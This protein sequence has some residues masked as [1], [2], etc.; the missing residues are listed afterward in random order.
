MIDK[1]YKGTNNNAL[2]V[3]SFCSNRCVMCCQPPLTEENQAELYD[4]NIKLIASAD[5][6]TDYVCITGGEPTLI[7]ERLFEYMNKIWKQMPHCCIHLLSNGR[8]FSKPKYIER[9]YEETKSHLVIGIPLHS[10]NYLDHD[11]IAGSKGA[12]YETIKG[13]HNLGVLGYEIE[14]RVVILKQNYKRL[15]K[16]AEFIIHN[17]PFVSQVSFMGLEVVGNA[18]GNFSKV[19]VEYAEFRSILERAVFLLDSCKIQVRIFN[20][21]HCC[22]PISLWTFSCKS[23][24]EWKK[25]NTKVCNKCVYIEDCCGIFSTSKYISSEIKPIEYK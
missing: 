2:F 11:L 25:T 15:D 5:S 4:R 20:I 17:L 12:F 9:F 23:I 24:S 13:L 18:Y 14:L 3:T 8:S 16:I 7:G 19:W 22:L 6:D 10:D 1:F 21:P